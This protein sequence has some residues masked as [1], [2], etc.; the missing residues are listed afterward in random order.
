M[1]PD[2]TS[3]RMGPSQGLP[4]VIRRL[5]FDPEPLLDAVGLN[6]R[7]FESAE[8]RIDAPLLGRLLH[9]TA[10]STGRDD[11][12]LLLA[13]NFKIEQ[14]GLLGMIMAEGPDVRTALRNLCRM[15]H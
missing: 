13:E 10:R 5:G 8:N 6:E 15:L 12:G 1:K 9:L 7:Q 4:A 2:T 11:I 3:F 14:L